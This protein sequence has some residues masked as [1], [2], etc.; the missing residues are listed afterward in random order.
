MIS[1]AGLSWEMVLTTD[2]VSSKFIVSIYVRLRPFW[3]PLV[4]MCLIHKVI[5]ISHA[6]FHCNRLTVIQDIQDYTSLIFLG[7]TV[8]C[9]LCDAGVLHCDPSLSQL[10]VFTAR[11]CFLS[12]FYTSGT[13]F[14]KDH[15]IFLIS[16]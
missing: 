9:L 15:K 16:F 12:L 7:H 10:V 13:R 2:T 5:R 6:K 3:T 11:L 1:C 14:L 8:Y 4:C